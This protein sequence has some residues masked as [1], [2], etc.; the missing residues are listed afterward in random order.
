MPLKDLVVTER[1]T[2]TQIEEIVSG[3]VQYHVASKEVTLLPASRNLSTKAKA[4]IYLVALQGWIYIA[5]EPIQVA[6]KP[7]QI[8]KAL[9]IKGNTL[10]PV[11]KEL[12]DSHL[13]KIDGRSYTVPVSALSYIRAE[14]NKSTDGDQGGSKKQ[15]KKTKHLEASGKKTPTAPSPSIFFDTLAQSDYFD[16][17]R[18]LAD[19]HQ[20]FR[21]ATINIPKSSL[22]SILIKAVRVN[23]LDRE[24]REI[25]GSRVYVYAR[26]K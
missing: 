9:K 10:R 16:E 17:P 23:L 25:G 1:L 14:L 3:Y 19:I 18:S 24:R 26:K 15:T 5:N 20:R 12:K 4:L 13:V 8:E 2:E 11:L 22:P 6:A 21:Q 7:A